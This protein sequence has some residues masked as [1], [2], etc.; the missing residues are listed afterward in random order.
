MARILHLPHY[1]TTITT[2]SNLFNPPLFTLFSGDIENLPKHFPNVL[3]NSHIL[4]SHLILEI[5]Y[6]SQALTSLSRTEV[7]LPKNL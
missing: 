3:N 2:P 5:K 7:L 6:I 4:S 1:A